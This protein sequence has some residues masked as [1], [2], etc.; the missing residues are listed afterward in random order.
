LIK[1]SAN[2]TKILCIGQMYLIVVFT[3]F[4]AW[5]YYILVSFDP[6]RRWVSTIIIQLSQT[7]S[8]GGMWTDIWFKRLKIFSGQN[9]NNVAEED[10][11]IFF[12]TFLN[13]IY[14]NFFY[15]HIWKRGPPAQYFFRE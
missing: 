4:S 13:F 3:L 10:E 2:K 8:A 1:Q 11:Q 9:I 5:D 6:I 12:K 15:L 7:N 14:Y